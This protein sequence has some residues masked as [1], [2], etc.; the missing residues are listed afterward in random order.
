MKI[1]AVTWLCVCGT[2]NQTV[3]GIAK[4]SFC[5]LPVHITIV[6]SEKE[7]VLEAHSRFYKDESVDAVIESTK[8]IVD[9]FQV[10]AMIAALVKWSSE[11]LDGATVQDV[12]YEL[13]R[14]PYEE[15]LE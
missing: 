10:I 14:W 7:Y 8:K 11:H 5:E 13:G 2:E 3:K 4:C 15:M 9:K 1:T 12:L 6:R